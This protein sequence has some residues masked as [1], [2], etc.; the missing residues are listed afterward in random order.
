[1]F[2]NVFTLLL[3]YNRLLLNAV[4]LNAKVILGHNLSMFDSRIAI[5]NLV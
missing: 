5:C 1:M 3:F 2:Y 4:G